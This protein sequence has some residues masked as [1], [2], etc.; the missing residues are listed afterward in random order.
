MEASFITC[1][2]EGAGF[3]LGEYVHTSFILN[4]H[5]QF[6]HLVVYFIIWV[7]FFKSFLWTFA[8]RNFPFQ[9]R[10]FVHQIQNRFFVEQ[11]FVGKVLR[12]AFLSFELI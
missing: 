11:N 7:C 12:N 1:S 5:E 6:V 4:V 10:I 3:D 2:L 9:L 8:H